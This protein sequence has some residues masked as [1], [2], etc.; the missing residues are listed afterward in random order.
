V[1]RAEKAPVIDGKLDETE[2]AGAAVIKG[3]TPCRDGKYQDKI[4]K[5]P[6]TIRLLWDKDYLYVAYECTDDDIVATLT[7]RDSKLYTEDVCEVFIDPMGDGRQYYEIEV[8]PN[9]VIFDTC[10]ITTAEPEY[11]EAKRFTPEFCNKNLW[12]FTEWNMEGLKTATQRTMK[13]GKETGWICE[14]AIPAKHLM[15]R[16]GLAKLKPCELRANFMRYDWQ[17]NP[18]GNGKRELLHMNWAPVVNGC[19]HISPSAMG[20][21]N[22]Q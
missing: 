2:W 8:S 15:K 13:D 7:E 16:R 4:D 17:P 6:T 11:T 3:L 14:M 12:V 21:V 1:P 19:P 22:L 18:K 10:H 20:I 9:N 5:I